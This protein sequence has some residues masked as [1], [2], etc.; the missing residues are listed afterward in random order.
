[1]GG[2]AGNKKHKK[3]FCWAETSTHSLIKGYEANIRFSSAIVALEW[4]PGLHAW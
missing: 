4:N 2:T 3:L 1:M